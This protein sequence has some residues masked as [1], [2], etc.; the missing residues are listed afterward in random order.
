MGLTARLSLA[1]TILSMV[2]VTQGAT[3]ERV[4]SCR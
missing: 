3:A 4:K 1:A 2:L